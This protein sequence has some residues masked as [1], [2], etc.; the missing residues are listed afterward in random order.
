MIYRI[1]LL[2]IG[3]I[4]PI[5]ANAQ[6]G[7]GIN[8]HR[9]QGKSEGA[10]M[11]N[12]ADELAWQRMRNDSIYTKDVLQSYLDYKGINV[13]DMAKTNILRPVFERVVTKGKQ[14]K[15]EDKSV[16]KRE[17]YEF[18]YNKILKVLKA[19]SSKKAA[20]EDYNQRN[21]WS[22]SS[23][24]TSLKEYCRHNFE[25]NDSVILNFLKDHDIAFE[26]IYMYYL[27]E[28]YGY[29][30]NSGVKGLISPNEIQKEYSLERFDELHRA[31]LYNKDK[32]IEDFYGLILKEIDY[33]LSSSFYD[34]PNVN[35]AK[36]HSLFEK[37][38]D[39]D[40]VKKLKQLYQ[41]WQSIISD[42]RWEKYLLSHSKHFK[43]AC[44]LLS[45]A[46]DY[47]KTHALTSGV[48]KEDNIN[49]GGVVPIDISRL[50]GSRSIPYKVDGNNLV[51]DGIC[52]LNYVD[53]QYDKATGNSFKKY[54]VNLQ[55]LV[56]VENGV[57]V[58]KT[59]SGEQKWWQEDKR[60]WDKTKGGLIQK[61]A[62]TLE[63][64]PVITKTKKVT[65]VEDL[66]FGSEMN[67]M[68]KLLHFSGEK[69]LS[70]S[71]LVKKYIQD[72]KENKIFLFLIKKPL[73]SVDISKIR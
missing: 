47:R 42:Y 34:N 33:P 37:D 55:M 73:K 66:G 4:M 29:Y 62:K 39:S 50:Y 13:D 2:F 69:D 49:M 35:K 40:N 58:S 28:D 38:K 65:K 30:R 57:A 21:D 27:A 16:W 19:K 53:E 71:C 52:T 43:E 5:L 44:S 24:F 18:E 36:I 72:P 31:L 7:Q 22:K 1:S 11:I 41:Q 70:V 12:Y 64:K 46:L 26:D 14:F 61:G 3:F 60:V 15:E 32:T 17:F 23:L 48:L 45:E 25:D 59:I 9:A 8:R 68:L 63:A 51:V 10:Q 54:T 56:K 6:L 67:E 20:D